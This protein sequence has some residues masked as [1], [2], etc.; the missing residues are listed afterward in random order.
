M[1]ILT[2]ENTVYDLTHLPSELDEDIRY[3]VLNNSNPSTP[4]F[5]FSPL[6]IVDV[7]TSPAVV[8]QIGD[9]E[10]TVPIE[11]SIAV[12]DSLSGND[13]EIIPLTSFNDRGFEAFCYNPLT[14]FRVEYKPMQIVN[15]YNEVKWYFPHLKQNNLLAYPISNENESL[16]IFINNSKDISKQNEIIDL[17]KLL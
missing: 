14:S 13:V 2:V 12:G 6:I 5:Y 7:F 1:K 10:V 15:V 16:C 8:L 3:A 17:H 11:W 9:H 4:D